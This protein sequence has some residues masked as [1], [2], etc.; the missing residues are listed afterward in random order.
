MRASSGSSASRSAIAAI[1]AIGRRAGR[2]RQAGRGLRQRRADLAPVLRGHAAAAGG[3][4][5]VVVVGNG[6]VGQAEGG[7]VLRQPRRQRGGLR[8]APIDRPIECRARSPVRAACRLQATRRRRAAPP[9]RW[10][11]SCQAQKISTQS[12]WAGWASEPDAG[13]GTDNPSHRTGGLD[14][15]KRRAAGGRRG[16][17]LAV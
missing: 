1:H 2:R 12:E 7:G 14:T 11:R 16:G 10:W 5:T 17:T 15:P 9:R 4:G 13:D 6:G 8:H 3:G